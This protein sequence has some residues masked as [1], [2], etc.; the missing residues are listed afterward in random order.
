MK[1][2]YF[3][4][5]FVLFQNLFSQNADPNYLRQGIFED[6]NGKIITSSAAQEKFLKERNLKVQQEQQHM[7]KATQPAVEMCA[8]GGFEQTETVSG[9]QYIKNFLYNIGDPPGPTQCKSI[10]NT[11]DTYIPQ[12]T[13][14]NTALMATSVPANYIDPFMGDIKAFDQYAL[15]INHT[16][17]STYGSIVQGK[18][19]KTNNETQ[20][21]F[22]YKAVLQSVYDTSHTDNQPFFKAR[23]LNKNG[24]V[25]SE[26]CLVGDE[27]NCI[28]TKVPAGGYGYVTLYTD[29]WQSGI[30]D[31][32]SIPNNEN[33]T[34][35][36][37]ASRCG[38][39]GHFG[40][41]YVDDLCIL[42]STENF[43]GSVTLDP[44]YSICPTLP[45]NVCGNYTLPN[46]GGVAATLKTLTLKLR[47]AGG[48]VVYTTTTP[49]TLDTANKKFCF[50]LLPQNFPNTINSNYNVSV[51][52]DFDVAA[53]SGGGACGSSGGN[54]AIFGSA[55]DSDANPG[56]DISFLNCS[57]SCDISVSTA[58]LSKCDTDYDGSESFDLR[59]FDA[60]VVPSTTGLTFSYF[61]DYSNAY[62]NTGAITGSSAY[63]SAS[64]VLYVRVSR[65][66]GCYKI[67]PVD[68]EV[69]NPTA[70]ITGILNVCSG[71]TEL[72]A[73]PGAT[74]LWSTGE[75]SQNIT[76]TT[77]GVYS[78]TV[79][80]SFGC[81]ST[82]SVSIEPSQT[83]VTPTLE[84]TQPSCFVATGTVK[85]VSPASQYSFDNGLTWGS[86]PVKTGLYP[87]NYKV[88]IKT[89]NGCTSYPQDVTITPVLTAYPSCSA[90]QPKFCGD[91]GSITV[92]NSAAYY[93]FDNG[94]TWVTGSTADHLQPGN[95][96]I[97]T[98]DISGC[99]SNA[100]IVN[101]SS[102]TL[103]SPD[104]TLVNPACS[105][106]GTIT[107]N[108]PSDFYTFNGGQTWVTSNTL[109]NAISG[110]FSVGI[111]NSLGCTSVFVSI[112][113]QPFQNTSP[114]YSVIQPACGQDGTVYISTEAD[115]YSF[116][117]GATWTTSNMKD[118]PPG[119]Y[120][121]KIKNAAGCQSQ[122][123]SVYLY[124]PQLP[125]PFY[126]VSQPTCGNNGSITINSVSD[127]YSFD[128]GTT[129]VTTNTKSLPAGSYQIL[130]KNSLGCKSSAAYVSLT[131]VKL[132]K[133]DVMTVQ[134]T[135][136]AKG[137][138]TVNT[139]ADLYSI[140]GGT[141]WS[142]S[143]VFSN[144]SGTS[145][146]V[147][148]KN[149]QGCVSETNYVYFNQIY[150]AEP[151][152]I[153]VNP[154]CGNV[155]S[156]TFTSPADFYSING[157]SSWS[158]S[159]VFTNLNASTGYYLMVKN[160]ANCMSA[161]ISVYMN[162]TNL[163][164]PS[165]T[166][167]QP[168]CGTKGSI[169][170]TSPGSS[171]SFDGGNTWS[172]SPV[173]NNITSGYFY[174]QVK[175]ASCVSTSTP[176]TINEFFL[177]GPSYTVTHPSCG[178]GGS[179][180]FTTSAAQYS[181]NGGQ[182]WSNTATFSNL[183]DGYYSLMVQNTLGCRSS[184][185]GASV[186]LQKYYLPK[187]DVQIIQ[188]T[189]TVKGSIKIMTPAA[190]YSFDGGQT[191]GTVNEK[192]DLTSGY[193]NVVI[194]N[195][196]GCTSNPYD[197]SIS[198]TAFFL[199]APFVK[200]VQPTCS[201]S[202]SITVVS[203]A[204]QY[205][206]DNG[207][208][209]VTNP[210]LLNPSP[211][212]YNIKI[213]NAA[214]CTSISTS[215]S[216][217]KFYLSQPSYTTVQPT[218]AVPKGTIFI[219]TVADLYSFDNGTTWTTN[220]VKNNLNSGT[221]YLLIKN[222]SGC[223]SQSAYVYIGSAPNIPAT[224]AVSLVQPTACDATDGTIT[225]TTPGVSYT[226]NDGASWTNDPV[227]RNVGSGTYI[228]RIKT[229]SSGCESA[230]V[231]VT[232][233]SGI[234]IAAPA[235]SLVQP[236]CSVATG[237]VTVTTSAATYSFDDGLTFV[238]SNTKSGLNPGVYKIKIKNA[239]GC[240]S[241]VTSATVT[242]QAPL[243]APAFQVQQP[244]C[245]SAL[246]TLLI[247]TAAAEYSFDNG[248][249]YG[250]SATKSGVGPG[251]YSLMI[252]DAAGCISL[253]GIATV[254]P[255]P[256]TPSAPQIS[257]SA[258]SGCTASSGT[259][260]VISAA[261]FYSYDDGATWVTN[262]SANLS[263]G[264]YQIRI[265][266]SAT[267]CS[268]PATAA[269]VVPPPNAP[270]LPL[271]AVAQP[272]SC[273]NPYGTITITSTEYQ[274]SFDNGATYSSNAVSSLLSPGIYTLKVRNSAGCESGAVAVTIN[275]PA[276]T[277]LQPTAAV[278]QIDCAHPSAKI[279][280]N[281]SA[282]QYSIDDGMTWQNSNIF[283]GL[284]PKTY[285]LRTK[286]AL[287]C[288][289]TAR[290]VTVHPFINPTP[291]PLVSAAQ[292]FC[293]QQQATVADLSAGGTQIRWYLNATGGSTL[294]PTTALVNG[295]TYYVTQT[296]ASCES[297]RAPVQINIFSTATPTGPAAQVFCVS[298]Y[299]KVSDLTVNGSQIK[300]YS[301][302]TGTSPLAADILLQDGIT[303]YATQTENGCE[304]V[305]RLAVTVSLVITNIPAADYLAP[306]LCSDED[307]TKKTDLAQYQPQLVANSAGYTYRYYTQNNTL[308]SD[309]AHYTLITGQNIFFV[310]INAAS[311]CSAKVKLTVVLNASPV[312]SV[313]PSAEYCPGSSV[314]LDAGSQPA[315]TSYSWSYNGVFQSSQRTINAGQN[316]TYAITVTNSSGCSTSKATTVKKVD[317][318]VITE[319]KIENNT[320]QIMASGSGLLEYSVDGLLWQTSS[321]FYNVPVGQHK[322]YVRSGLQPCAVAEQ[323]F[324]IFLI[325]NVFSPNGDGVNDT[326]RIEGIEDYPG[327][328]IRVIDRFGT[329]VLDQKV[330]GS[331]S[332][333]G[334]HLSR[335]LP[336]GN[337]WYYITVSDGRIL[338]GY[339]MIKN[340]N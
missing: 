296:L 282:S 173:K 249:T 260:A 195:A 120:R 239:T 49:A 88:M 187:P 51:T 338:S 83:A 274:Y 209:W 255:Q 127:F 75:S 221:Y 82:A 25:V 184:S 24:V 97:R 4:I 181:I 163:A 155:G 109:S 316:G 193:Y 72:K 210:V 277:P 63:L 275:I 196:Q 334:Q 166:V 198:I 64:T 101:I 115:F 294:S 295:A 319:I 207:S 263:P 151:T 234:T 52:A 273:T 96:S 240:I 138:I 148:I 133:A 180:T 145:Y 164:S 169:T 227:K 323:T 176:V 339:V 237:S 218:C 76:V 157:G 125:Y 291:K 281:E 202:G 90:V 112:Y 6:S 158:T 317:F 29:K 53:T 14:G 271:F 268:S 321:L 200:T 199:P 220:P 197:M 136:T 330:S 179:I 302:I 113:L 144:L 98:K 95:Y 336:T 123:S 27:K 189:C 280:V 178:T 126:T 201:D 215:T 307:G 66:A 267:G 217:S 17:S 39:G 292:N 182:T 251:T 21:K 177:P 287:G 70:N 325:S 327:S 73:S 229:N 15:K 106:P 19:F 124:E 314:Q 37:M 142:A 13:P 71:S 41:A 32:S 131:E 265:K 174:V 300:W 129:W 190:M 313:P 225:I 165:V 335:H 42:Q 203:Q 47:D 283:T 250:P 68:L 104:Y 206:F 285:L 192:T 230:S 188:P 26:F 306:A 81:A 252:K 36:F 214:G 5:F 140:N 270:A 152:Y 223:V 258:P 154:S 38:L 62:N 324:T 290:Q 118:L 146:N 149:A 253:A 28:F 332:W 191:W 305:G 77:T 50:A 257:V 141:T 175:D 86:N 33:F 114:Q 48:N 7:H 171:Y 299:A 194:K 261:A 326:W 79:T 110:N 85:V 222:A 30:L 35:E 219:N 304:S 147:V 310:E 333:N 238:Y 309:P 105:A 137:S 116:D 246:G 311:G 168:T 235:V 331:F 44:L 58:K 329:V 91:T 254:N 22:N 108:T 228:I 67:I 236:T 156:I 293:V 276:D 315:G 245:S 337:Y 117:N 78:V 11:A 279:T 161:G 278:E 16:G 208:T 312:V 284:F 297:E 102:T 139:P 288:Q 122:T 298:Q 8:N 132:P 162:T 69:K 256:L 264:V 244:D 153:V 10:S 46:S 241:A 242:A 40:Y 92:N 135:C 12:Y 130:V 84:I 232:L 172:T 259:V 65:D 56:W 204:A 31:I 1:N 59:L 247:T 185:Y 328:R 150:L 107:I 23:I 233:H 213:K 60:L 134:P 74:Y 303:Y 93:S 269:T 99:I 216:V 94:T 212:Y 186:T 211:G 301:T 248:L 205:S 2:F 45:L 43:V 54:T 224:P 143:N 226:F 128:G 18:R 55:T 9:K 231:P 266:L 159:P 100:Q 160:S 20:L 289:S 308:I 34:V 57:L 87:G 167:V 3:L 318:P 119:T 286:N 243:P 183:A 320:V 262:A 61:A 103:G 272:L 322:A 121:I 80:D 89:L 170:V 111:K 340:R